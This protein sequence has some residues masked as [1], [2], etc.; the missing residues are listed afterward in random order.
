MDV[1]VDRWPDDAVVPTLARLVPELPDLMPLRARDG[2]R[3]YGTSVG[4]ADHD[5]L[6][7]SVRVACASHGWW[8]VLTPLD[9]ADVAT[10]PW[11]LTQSPDQVL[12]QAAAVDPGHLIAAMIGSQAWAFSFDDWWS[13]PDDRLPTPEELAMHISPSAPAGG[14]RRGS[15]ADLTWSLTWL[16]VMPVAGCEIP[17]VWGRPWTPN[18]AWRDGRSGRLTLADH[19]GVLRSW[20]QRFGADLMYLSGSALAL[21]VRRPPSDPLE[22]AGVAL[23]QYAYCYD[24]DQFIGNVEDVAQEQVP[25]DRWHF[26]WD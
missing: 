1:N 26:W 7:R 25:R 14:A 12:T 22:I 21:A 16:Y 20:H 9:P 11:L 15:A 2:S 23:E 17:A 10:A 3:M 24:L 13:D 6:W 18:W 19:V 8:P 5:G 4:L